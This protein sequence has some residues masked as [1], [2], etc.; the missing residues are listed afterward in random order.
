MEGWVIWFP[1]QLVGHWSVEW[2]RKVSNKGGVF[3]TGGIGECLIY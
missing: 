3:C 2:C 1:F